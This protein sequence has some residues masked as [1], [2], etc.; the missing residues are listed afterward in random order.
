ME[1]NIK[2]TVYNIQ[3]IRLLYYLRSTM[4]KVME[5]FEDTEISASK[6]DGIIQ[7][8]D[9]QQHEQR[10]Q[11]IDAK[12]NVNWRFSWFMSHDLKK[13]LTQNRRCRG[14]DSLLYAL[15][16]FSAISLFC[17]VAMTT[18]AVAPVAKSAVV[19]N[20]KFI[21]LC[22]WWNYRCHRVYMGDNLVWFKTKTECFRVNFIRGQYRY[23]SDSNSYSK[24]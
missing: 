14:W 5:Q 10:R 17:S 8:N 22:L 4:Y 24:R 18:P 12:R 7:G 6:C 11:P 13:N 16:K 20:F 23:R 9:W 19:K 3:L 15:C 1:N 21:F 2:Y